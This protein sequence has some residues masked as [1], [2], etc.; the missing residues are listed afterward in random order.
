MGSDQLI[1]QLLKGIADERVIDF[2]SKR[3]AHSKLCEVERKIMRAIYSKSSPS[4]IMVYGPTGVGK[5]TLLERL[6]QDIEDISTK[7]SDKIPCAS[8]ELPS[9]STK[10]FS[11]PGYYKKVLSAL[12]EPLVHKK[13]SLERMGK[14]TKDGTII[15]NRHS[16]SVEDYREAVES[17]LRW[18]NPDA[19]LIDEAQHL[20]KI[21]SSE[22]GDQMDTVKSMANISGVKHVF[23][24]TYELLNLVDLSGQLNRR[25]VEIEFPR[26]RFNIEEEREEFFNTYVNLL[27]NLPIEHSSLH[28]V[29][30]EY[31]YERTLGCVG[32]LKDWL[33]RGLELAL[34]NNDSFLDINH[35][36]ET[37]ESN[38][39][40][41]KIFD[42]IEYGESKLSSREKLDSSR[43]LGGGTNPKTVPPKSNSR[44]NRPPGERSP[45]RDAV[46]QE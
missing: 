35:L 46:G 10:G 15:L 14:V 31:I 26:Y 5:T 21:R 24:G 33:I 23:L 36:N 18:R 8:F 39:S 19:L 12:N 7:A 6:V 29:G 4:I 32:L 22:F 20:L 40:L 2:A 16:S 37:E 9:V 42:E 11:W 34:D 17:A 13:K 41:N 38:A 44:G 25:T 43:V 30:D 1:A 28:Q 3:V 27:R 45:S